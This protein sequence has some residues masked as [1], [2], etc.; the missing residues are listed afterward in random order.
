MRNHLLPASIILGMTL[1]SCGSGGKKT[2]R[3]P[4]A[5]MAWI[6]TQDFVKQAIRSPS[7][8]DFGSMFGDYQSPRDVVRQSGPNE[9]EINA[10]VDA[11]NGFGATVRTRFRCKVRYVG[12]GRW[13]RVSLVFEER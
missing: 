13:Q 10:W 11:Q 1:A 5:T 9:F 8:A 3:P 7:T 4:D 2:E 12:E 6:M